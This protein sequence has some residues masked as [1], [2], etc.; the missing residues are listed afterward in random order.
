MAKGTNYSSERA[1]V[2]DAKSGLR[3]MRLAHYSCIST[4]LYF[5]MG[6]F[7]TDETHVVFISQRGAARDAPW[8]LFRVQTDGMELVQV[9]EREDLCGIAF[10]PALGC[11]FYQSGGELLKTDIHTLKEGAVAKVPGGAGKP[12]YSLATIDAAGKSYFGNCAGPKNGDVLF[13]VDVATGAVDVLYHSKGQNHLHVD[14]AGKTLHFNDHDE[15]GWASHLIDAD[16]TNLRRSCFREFA[17]HTWF[18]TTGK[19]QGTLLPPGK[20]LALRGEHDTEFTIL[21]EGRYYWHSC[22]SPDAQWIVSD[23]N[24]PQEGI[25]LLHVPTGRVSYVCDPQSAPSHPQWTHPHP[26]LSPGMKY[27][28]FNSDQTGIGQVYLAELT[29]EFLDAARKPLA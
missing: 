22:A 15:V 26:S 8:D 9:T 3:V 27:V 11:L 17:H 24:W 4:N 19:M 6:S 7:T 20:A 21:A 14:P 12:G 2:T 10:S 18:G 25:Y 23:T 5:E 29:S 1:I 28:L 16:G 13:R